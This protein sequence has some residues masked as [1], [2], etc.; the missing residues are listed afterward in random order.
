MEKEEEEEKRGEK[1]REGGDEEKEEGEKMSVERE[2]RGGDDSHRNLFDC[3]N[4]VISCFISVVVFS[5]EQCLQEEGKG[6]YFCG[7]NFLP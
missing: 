1:V 2:G 5:I 4:F 6:L 3:L 7:A